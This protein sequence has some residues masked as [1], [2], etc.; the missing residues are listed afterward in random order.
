M[1]IKKTTSAEVVTNMVTKKNSDVKVMI[2]LV[3]MVGGLV[4][5]REEIKI[6]EDKFKAKMEPLKAKKELLQS[7]IIQILKERKEFSARFETAT[8]TLAVRKTAQVV[9]EG[10]AVEALVLKGLNDYVELQLN[11]LFHE[12]YAKKIATGETTL[13]GIEVRETEYLSVKTSEA[14]ERRKVTTQEYK[15]LRK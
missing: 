12:T 9:D 8:A 1:P 11:E 7:G 14:T 2:P 15:E 13:P 4:A 5:L 10:L 3:D 6:K